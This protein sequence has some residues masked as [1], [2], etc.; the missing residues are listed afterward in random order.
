MINYFSGK[1]VLVFP[2]WLKRIRMKIWEVHD[3]QVDAFRIED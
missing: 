1:E 2:H 3:I